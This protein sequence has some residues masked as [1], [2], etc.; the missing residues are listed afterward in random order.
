MSKPFLLTSGC[1]CFFD[2]NWKSSNVWV[3]K[4]AK[5]TVRKQP[6]NTIY[7]PISI[8]RKHARCSSNG[9]NSEPVSDKD[10]LYSFYFSTKTYGYL[11]G[12]SVMFNKTVSVQKRASKVMRKIIA[13]LF[14]NINWIFK[15]NKEWFFCQYKIF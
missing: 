1:L 14:E 13:T 7:S 4:W 8:P 5:R 15:I 11:L 10:K 12:K 6:V 9:Y 3:W 2:E